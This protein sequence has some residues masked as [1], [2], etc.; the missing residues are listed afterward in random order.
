VEHP[1]ILVEFAGPDAALLLERGGELLRSFEL[2]GTRFF[3]Y[4]GPRARKNL[5]RLQNF[6][7]SPPSRNSRWLPAPPPT[8]SD[9]T[10][11]P[12]RF[13]P[14]SSRERRMVHSGTARGKRFGDTESDARPR[15]CVVVYPG[16]YKSAAKPERRAF[17]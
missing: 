15:R 7:F 6:R 12:Y 8:K 13:A 9:R 17:S 2:L 5:V 10:G 4:K 1:E 16:N 14:M 11:E 3:A